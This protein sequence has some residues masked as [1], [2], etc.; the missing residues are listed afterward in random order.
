MI[1]AS[2]RCTIPRGSPWAGESEVVPAACHMTVRAEARALCTP[3]DRARDDRKT[4]RRQVFP[5]AEL[6]ECGR[7]PFASRIA[8]SSI[9]ELMPS[10]STILERLWPW[11]PLTIRIS[12]T[13]AGRRSRDGNRTMASLALPST[14]GAATR[15]F[16]ASP[17]RP[18][19]HLVAQAPAR[20]LRV[21][22]GF[23]WETGFRLAPFDL[24]PKIGD[25]GRVTLR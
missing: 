4:T 15:S 19:V 17:K 5:G 12:K 22:G 23:S 13:W 3:A 6:P 14:G 24:R 1:P 2:I 16:H 9:P 20:I 10:I 11:K 18:P 7:G 25:A 21:T 8:R